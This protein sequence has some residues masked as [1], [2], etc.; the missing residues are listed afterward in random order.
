[1]TQI[2]I[3]ITTESYLLT[4]SGEG[5][6]LIDADIVFHPLGYPHF[7]GRRF[8]GLLRESMEEVLEMMGHNNVEGTIQHIFGKEDRD[9]GDGIIR[10]PN[11]FLKGWRHLKKQT[12]AKAA[13]YAFQPAFIKKY[14]TTEIQQTAI[15]QN[16]GTAKDRS[17]RNYR[18]LKPSNDFY[19]TLEFAE[20]LSED[21]QTWFKYALANLRYA[22]T[23]RNR[24]FGKI[25]VVIE[26][27]TAIIDGSTKDNSGTT[28]NTN[29]NTL[30]IRLTTQS[31]IV[32]ALQLGEQNTVSTER[33]ISGNRLRGLLANTYIRKKL[34]AGTEPHQ[35][36]NFFNLFLS[37]S[38]QFGNLYFNNTVPVPLHIHEF[39]GYTHESMPPVNVFQWKE[40]SDYGKYISKPIGGHGI[41]VDET[42]KH[43][44]KKC[45][46]ST[47]FF[48]HNS[49]Y[50]RK[51][52]RS[53]EQGSDTG[54]EG[55]GGIFYYEALNEDQ[56]FEGVITSA[57]SSL[58]ETLYELINET[59]TFG[60]GKS[61]SAQ[62][63]TVMLEAF[64]SERSKDAEKN[65]T[66]SN[67]IYLLCL[68]SPLVLLNEYGL[69]SPTK[70]ALEAELMAKLSATVKVND[71]A[72]AF[73]T[74]EQYNS[75]WQSKS[76]KYAA[77]K[78]GSVFVVEVSDLANS[79]NAPAQ[80]GE[81]NIQGFGKVRWELYNVGAAK[82][83]EIMDYKP[84]DTNTNGATE[85]EILTEIKQAY[86]KE[87]EIIAIKT[88][89]IKDA[90][91]H[92]K[93][94]QLKNHLIGRMEMMIK[95]A[96]NMEAITKWFNDIKEKPA[97]KSLKSAELLDDVCKFTV[98]M[99]NTD[100]SFEKSKCYWLTF[101]QTF[102]KLNRS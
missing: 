62:Y 12:K 55:G 97:E 69:P 19:G 66:L 44:I 16:S 101:F 65:A 102:R 68:Q 18:V 38:V 67:G 46:P 94:H 17:L 8:K 80:L 39:K 82:Q 23:R 92:H 27:E 45:S 5:D 28:L 61:K 50:M 30:N 56:T 91:A 31:P 87:K 7:P 3:K 20:S 70:A 40:N 10:V 75:V 74:V 51:A 6:V 24:G 2:P 1:M 98:K 4:G 77:Y 33:Y 22:G 47:S 49:R 64:Q 90:T 48:F 96:Q 63:G 83:I 93:H 53:V 58:L 78:E 72:V 14:F 76:G 52:G 89:A 71:S 9:E 54:V 85:S 34:K 21:Q 79:V 13:E 37:G 95:N 42:D 11:F 81:W 32:L 99:N 84:S 59:A 60:I 29:S 15:D 35:D 43:K 73:T 36:L 26:N 86:D 88:K 100:L 57:D 41:M 25:K